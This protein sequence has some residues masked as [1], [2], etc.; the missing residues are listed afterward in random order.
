VLE[1]SPGRK[2]NVEIFLLTRALSGQKRLS[3]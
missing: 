1:I 3:R 2:A